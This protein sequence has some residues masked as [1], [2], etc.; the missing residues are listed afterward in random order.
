M[1]G[2]TRQ[3]VS[4]AARAVTVA[5]DAAQGFQTI[6]ATASL[7]EAFVVPPWVMK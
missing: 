6:R 7:V 5:G 4:A 2:S 1:S 3:E